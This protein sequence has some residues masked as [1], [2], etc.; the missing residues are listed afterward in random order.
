[1]TTEC[2]ANPE[3]E[4]GYSCAQCGDLAPIR[5]NIAPVRV[6]IAEL[7][8]MWDG[9]PEEARAR[10]FEGYAEKSLVKRMGEVDDV[11][12]TCLYLMRADFVTGANALVEGGALLVPA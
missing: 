2:P 5:V 4:Q 12:E 11:V 7:A 8:E 3:A 9:L 10:L 1:M 6:N